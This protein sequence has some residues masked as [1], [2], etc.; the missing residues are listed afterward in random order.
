LSRSGFIPA[1]S[2]AFGGIFFSSL[3]FA[4][5]LR[6]SRWARMRL[7]DEETRKGSIPMFSRRVTVLGASFVW[8]VERTR[9]PVRAAFTP[10]SAVS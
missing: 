7:R 3:Q 2:S 1:S 5:I 9:C 4:Q 6:A 8:S 10:I